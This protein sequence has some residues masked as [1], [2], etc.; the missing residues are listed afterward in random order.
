M[1]ESLII[2]NNP[3]EKDF[4][5]TMHAGMWLP[6]LVFFVAFLIAMAVLNKI[7]AH[8][9][10]IVNSERSKRTLWNVL[11]L[12]TSPARKAS[13]KSSGEKINLTLQL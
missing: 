5:E 4:W 10:P 11:E 12:S 9:S 8:S 2:Y 13:D 3:F 1:T 6:A 7:P